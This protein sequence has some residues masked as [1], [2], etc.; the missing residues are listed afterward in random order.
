MH[1]Q[2]QPAS[3]WLLIVATGR[4][5]GK[6]DWSHPAQYRMGKTLV[7]VYAPGLDFASRI[8]QRHEPVL[9]QALLPHPAV[10]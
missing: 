6:F 4:F 2:E 10:E 1:N 7:I 8:L 5:F 3:G 9:V